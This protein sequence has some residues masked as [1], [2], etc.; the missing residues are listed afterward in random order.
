MS[1]TQVTMVF[2]LLADEFDIHILTPCFR[3][4][5]NKSDSMWDIWLIFCILPYFLHAQ[6]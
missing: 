1:L 4:K 6:K 2:G 5:Y 3:L